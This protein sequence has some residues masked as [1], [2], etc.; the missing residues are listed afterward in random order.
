MIDLNR[1]PRSM[2]DARKLIQELR[3]EIVRRPRGVVITAPTLRLLCE[4]EKFDGRK[5]WEIE[6][7]FDGKTF[8]FEQAK[9]KPVIYC[10][11][12]GET[13]ENIV[14]VLSGRYSNG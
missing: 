10:P 6:I 3:K 2:K 7:C 5:K 14:S 4:T 12:V 1:K 13:I 9:A 11:F 8:Y